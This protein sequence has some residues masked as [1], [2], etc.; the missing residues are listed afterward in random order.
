MG[1][2]QYG[3]DGTRG[4]VQA[5]TFDQ[6]V[7]RASFRSSLLRENDGAGAN[8]RSEWGKKHKTP[9]TTSLLAHQVYIDSAGIVEI[10]FATLASFSSSNSKDDATSAPSKTHLGLRPD[11][12]WH[13]FVAAVANG[14]RRVTVSSEREWEVTQRFFDA[15]RPKLRQILIEV[16]VHE[17][18]LDKA[19]QACRHVIGNP[20][21]ESSYP[22][23]V[24]GFNSALTLVRALQ[25][26][27]LSYK[28]VA[29]VS[30]AHHWWVA[31]PAA[32][33]V[34]VVDVVSGESYSPETSAIQES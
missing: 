8:E 28:A 4:I 1:I 21:H 14:R 22:G 2:V 15:I 25:A 33:G 20:A 26:A 7:A 31:P 29:P 32:G 27:P 5:M 16:F 30:R 9:D 6:E 23:R 13:V 3:K 17:E 11:V 24:S 34:S 18:C 10:L 19:D 12:P